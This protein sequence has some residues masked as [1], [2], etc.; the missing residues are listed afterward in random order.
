MQKKPTQNYSLSTLNLH[1]KSYSQVKHWQQISVIQYTS[2]HQSQ[3]ILGQSSCRT[4]R[5]KKLLTSGLNFK[6]LEKQLQFRKFWE[7]SRLNVMSLVL[8]FLLEVYRGALPWSRVR[9]IEVSIT[10]SDR[11]APLK[12]EIITLRLRDMRELYYFSDKKMLERKGISFFIT[13]MKRIL[14]NWNTVDE[15][16]IFH[17]LNIETTGKYCCNE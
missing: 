4:N 13:A 3:N 8:F 2:K 16:T 17:C 1:N 6:I 14:W 9:L 12:K 5:P 11:W 10:P 7:V 15:K